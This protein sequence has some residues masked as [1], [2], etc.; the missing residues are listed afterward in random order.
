MRKIT[1]KSDKGMILVNVDG[2]ETVCINIGEAFS[3]V[4][5]VLR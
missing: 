5:E 3:V 1:L 2:K 4:K